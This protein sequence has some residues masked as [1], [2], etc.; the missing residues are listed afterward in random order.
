MLKKPVRQD[1]MVASGDLTMVE[2]ISYLVSASCIGG[3]SWVVVGTMAG[4]RRREKN[5]RLEQGLAEYLQEMTTSK[6]N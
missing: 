3:L 2:V 5:R 6:T 1:G 4:A